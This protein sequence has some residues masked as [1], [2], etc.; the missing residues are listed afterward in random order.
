[1]G[2][3]TWRS[4]LREGSGERITLNPDREEMRVSGGARMRLPAE[5]ISGSS[6]FTSIK[7]TATNSASQ[8][9]SEI[10][11]DEYLLTPENAVFQGAV[12]AD[13]P[14]M[15]WQCETIHARFPA[16]TNTGQ[17]VAEQNV[18]FVLPEAQ[19]RGNGKRAVFTFGSPGHSTNEFLELT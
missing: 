6:A 18:K 17:V 8:Q 10:T 5:E 7:R 9:F 1:T 3:P 2:S 16:G 14:Q 12:H 11:A 13:H 19:I 15:K 4:G